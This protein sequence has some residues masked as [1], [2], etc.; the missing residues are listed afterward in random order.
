MHG[1]IFSKHLIANLM[2]TVPV[3]EFRK[4]IGVILMKLWNLMAYFSTTVYVQ[5]T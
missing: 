2:L 3:K 1:G 4:S 5:C